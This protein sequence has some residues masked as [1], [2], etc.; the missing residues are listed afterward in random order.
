MAIPERFRSQD[1]DLQ[2]DIGRFAPV[3]T[4]TLKALHA[5]D[6]ERDGLTR[7]LEEA[8]LRAAVLLG[9]EDGIYFEREPAD[10]RLL[11]E[12]E[13]QMMQAQARLD[14]LQAQRAML[15]SWLS[16][17]SPSEATG[18][19][20]NRAGPGTRPWLR[21]PAA[22][23]VSPLGRRLCRLTGWT[24]VLG[25]VY[26]TLSNIDQRPSVAWL[27]PD[28]E[29]LFA[30]FAAAVALSL[31][32]PRH[33]RLILGAG[34]VLVLGLELGQGWSATRHGTFHDV[35]VKA[36]GLGLGLASGMV[37]ERILQSASNA[38]TSVAR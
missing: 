11:V 19:S 14:Q 35:L 34:L 32:Y 30:F 27:F 4:E 25:I 24:I 12:A 6:Q 38:P 9:N 3:R 8:R 28:A 1:R 21:L 37:L 31:G 2:T 23:A 15:D 36:A 18:A 5:I 16:Q 17:A 22:L 10:E 29:Q 26:A 13:A 7:R 20:Q 33:C